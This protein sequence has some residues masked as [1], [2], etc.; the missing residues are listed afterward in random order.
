MT[1]FEAK[2]TKESKVI[3]KLMNCSGFSFIVKY[4]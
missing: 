4:K 2:K 3:C 1:I